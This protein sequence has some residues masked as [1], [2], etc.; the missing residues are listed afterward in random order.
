VVLNLAELALRGGERYERVH[1]LELEPIVLGRTGYRVLVPGGAL[2][3]VD[4]VTGGYLVT[5]ALDAKV[6]GPCARC[7]GE[8]VVQVHAEQQEFA[9][10]AKDGWEG[11]EASDFIKDLVL[12]VPGLAREALVLALPGQVVCSGSCKGLCSRCGEDLNKG[13]CGCSE[14]GI[15]RGKGA[16]RRQGLKYRG[17]WGKNT[18]FPHR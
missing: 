9:P 11:A 18:R 5:V 3:T 7:L 17:R 10:T 15:R 2:I 1:P 16:G 6:Y 13:P 8:A 12:D 4:R 14:D